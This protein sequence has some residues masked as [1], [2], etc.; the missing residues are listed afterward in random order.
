MNDYCVTKLLL[1][2]LITQHQ[3]IQDLTDYPDVKI[4]QSKYI[5]VYSQALLMLEDDCK[6]N[7]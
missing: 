3:L 4:E 7:L 2:T 5:K 6:R 1:T